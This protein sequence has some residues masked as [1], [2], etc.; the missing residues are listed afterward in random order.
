MKIHSRILSHIGWQQITIAGLAVSFPY[1]IDYCAVTQTRECNASSMIVQP[2]V[3][4]CYTE[5]FPATIHRPTKTEHT[6]GGPME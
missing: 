5:S 6:N 3:S 1:I 2:K 4:G